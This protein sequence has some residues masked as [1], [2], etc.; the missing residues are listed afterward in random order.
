M[1]VCVCVSIANENHNNPTSINDSLILSFLLKIDACVCVCVCVF[2]CVCEGEYARY[3][4]NKSHNLEGQLRSSW[5]IDAYK[6][7]IYFHITHFYMP[8][9]QACTGHRMAFLVLVDPSS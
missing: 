6:L 4:K 2:V 5:N 3:C 9:L 8:S 1:S 7:V